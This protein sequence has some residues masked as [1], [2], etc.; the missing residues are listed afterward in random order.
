MGVNSSVVE[1]VLP[2]L[3]RFQSLNPA[4]RLIVT[5]TVTGI[6]S[7]IREKIAPCGKRDKIVSKCDKPGIAGD[8][9]LVY[10]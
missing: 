4:Y 7:G 9:G 3:Q 1:I 8:S 5:S 2:K 6:N 10:R